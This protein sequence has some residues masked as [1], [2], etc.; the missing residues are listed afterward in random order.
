[1][2]IQA[3]EYHGIAGA[4]YTRNT[5]A[6]YRSDLSRFVRYIEKTSTQPATLASFTMPLLK[7]FIGGEI[8]AGFHPHTIARR[9]AS[10]RA[11]NRFLKRPVSDMEQLSMLLSGR[12]QSTILLASSENLQ[13]AHLNAVWNVMERATQAR[14]RRDL[15]LLAL[16]LETGLPVQHLLGMNLN[17]LRADGRILLLKQASGKT[18]QLSL[19]EAVQPLRRYLKEGRPELNCQPEE[20]ALWISQAGSRMTRQAV[21]QAIRGWGRRAGLPFTLNPRLL[22]HIAAQ[23][24][25]SSGLPLKQIQ[26][27]LG[28]QSSLSTLARLQRIALQNVP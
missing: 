15:A 13:P 17:D 1:M 18:E 28:H 24:L 20:P 14:A 8:T 16:L 2:A 7:A 21:W 6:A 27:R 10:L 11:F 3:F 5:L 12:P 26:L 23:R 9:I 22:S 4:L 25:A 19:D